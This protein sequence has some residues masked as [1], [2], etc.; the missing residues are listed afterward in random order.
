VQKNKVYSFRF[1]G[2][3]LKGKYIGEKTLQDLQKVYIF[4]D[5]KYKYP[6]KKEQIC[7]NSTQ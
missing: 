7:G 3:T 2:E 5:G 6:I 4:N 1:A